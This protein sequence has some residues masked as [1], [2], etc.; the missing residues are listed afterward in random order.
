MFKDGDSRLK[1]HATEDKLDT[2]VER[3]DASRTDQAEETEMDDEPETTKFRQY[4]PVVDPFATLRWI[5]LSFRPVTRLSFWSESPTREA[6]ISFNQES[7]QS[8][9]RYRMDFY[10]F[11]QIFSAFASTS[12]RTARRSSMVL[13]LVLGQQFLGSYGK[14]KRSSAVHK[15]V[16]TGTTNTRDVDYEWIPAKTLKKVQ[17]S[18]KGAKCSPSKAL[19]S[20]AGRR[21]RLNPSRDSDDRYPGRRAAFTVLDQR[22]L[23]LR[24]D[25]VTNEKNHQD[26]LRNVPVSEEK[27]LGDHLASVPTH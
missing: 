7:D 27:Y 15:T 6:T 23:A 18:L 16:K 21:R 13:L 3:E 14:C 20:E 5:C 2:E 11:L 10:Y 9:F 17:N 24:E 26:V 4:V 1:A 25:I 8:S 22:W 12:A 19:G